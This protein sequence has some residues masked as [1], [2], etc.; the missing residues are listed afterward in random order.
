MLQIVRALI[1]NVRIAIDGIDKDLYCT[2]NAFCDCD[3][4]EVHCSDTH[5]GGVNL[6]GCASETP[7][8]LSRSSLI[9]M[10]GSFYSG[11]TCRKRRL[12]RSLT[13]NYRR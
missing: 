2:E 10:F 5:T 6:T 4:R 3:P 11:L 7:P 1:T 8:A 12:F 13:V 9:S